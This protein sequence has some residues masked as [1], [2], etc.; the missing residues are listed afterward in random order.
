LDGV[1][2]NEETLALARAKGLPNAS[3]RVGDAYDLGTPTRPYSAVLCTFWWSHVPKER[4]EAFLAEAHR[5]LA[6]GAAV[7]F[8]DNTYVE[9]SST[10]I[11]RSDAR[12]NTYQS[13]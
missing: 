8:A 12:G 3:F 6:P 5:Q 7:L 10:P 13:R 4:L 1:D 9:G 11:T 2:A